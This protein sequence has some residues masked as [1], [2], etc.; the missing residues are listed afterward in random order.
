MSAGEAW[1]SLS[2][3]FVKA[4]ARWRRVTPGSKVVFVLLLLMFLVAF[5]G[6]HLVPY[7][8]TVG[9]ASDRLKPIGSPGHLLGTDGQGRDVFS[10]LISGA[11]VSLLTGLAPAVFA[12][13]I[14]SAIGLI[15]G[16][17]GRRIN[18]LIMRI[19]DVFY[20]FPAV[21]LAIAIAAALGP[22]IRNAIIALSLVFT[23]PIARVVEGQVAVIRGDDFMEA[24]A[25]SGA[26]R[27]RIAVRQ[28]LPNVAAPVIVYCTSLIGL[29]IVEAAGLS[30]LGLGAAPPRAEW[31]LMLNDGQSFILTSP[32]IAI[33]P[34]VAILV[35]SLL[36][37]LA[38]DRLAIELHVNRKALS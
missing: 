12:S 14:G 30:Y 7:S 33:V 29:C 35:A 17:A 28:V 31:G 11:P 24:A 16:L 21:L 25:S 6:P 3:G 13:V 20:V 15:A 26:G 22:G 9:E 8:P 34:A 36:F 2:V 37:N 38:G 10:R 23:P 19:L 4:P 18:N 5:I 32:G 1:Q 27:I